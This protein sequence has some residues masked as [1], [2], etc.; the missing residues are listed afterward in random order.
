M[1]TGGLEFHYE[2]YEQKS[3]VSLVENVCLAHLSIAAIPTAKLAHTNSN[4]TNSS[5]HL[6]SG[7]K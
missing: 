6:A 4:S 7:N 3:L 5:A 2:S 1:P